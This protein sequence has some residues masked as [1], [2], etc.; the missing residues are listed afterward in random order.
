MSK[1]IIKIKLEKCEKDTEYNLKN[2]FSAFFRVSKQDRIWE[3][4]DRMLVLWQTYISV[5]LTVNRLNFS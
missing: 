1:V 3:V 5:I 4:V 2:L